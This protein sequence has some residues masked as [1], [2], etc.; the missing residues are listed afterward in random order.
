[1]NIKIEELDHLF[2]TKERKTSCQ[3]AVGKPKE[4]FVLDPK[5]SNQINI[6][7]KKIPMLLR[8]KN[9]ILKMDDQ[10]MKR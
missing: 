9:V 10:N 4:I 7:I 6:G 3:E 5:R 8:P 2:Q 1:V